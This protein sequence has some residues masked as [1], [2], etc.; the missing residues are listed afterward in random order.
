MC[1]SRSR[2]PHWWTVGHQWPMWSLHQST[3]AWC[4]P[5]ALQ[6]VWCASMRPLMWWTSASG[7]C[8][9][10]S[11]ASSPA[12][13]SPGTPPGL[14]AIYTHLPT[15]SNMIWKKYSWLS[16]LFVLPFSSR[17][18]PPMI[19]VGSDD[20]NVTYSGKVQ[21]YEYNENTRYMSFTSCISSF[22]SVFL[23]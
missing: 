7:H 6:T 4:W 21:I 14:N 10:R 5:P 13:A 19:A 15:Q 16:Q 20:S 3:W 1:F 9:T 11:P 18:H 8:S 17:A 2:E 23:L 12:P 22:I